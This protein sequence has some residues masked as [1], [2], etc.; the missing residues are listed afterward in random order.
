M[1]NVLGCTIHEDRCPCIHPSTFLMCFVFF[2]STCMPAR[3]H[4]KLNKYYPP[5]NQNTN[6]KKMLQFVE[7]CK[8]WQRFLRDNFLSQCCHNPKHTDIIYCLPTI[9]LIHVHYKIT[10]SINTNWY[11]FHQMK[12]SFE[13]EMWFIESLMKHDNVLLSVLWLMS[14]SIQQPPEPNHSNITQN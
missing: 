8:N 9:I 4:F 10:G 11:F 6:T 5:P 1:Q 14:E 7:Y 2:F 3:P 13:N 12:I